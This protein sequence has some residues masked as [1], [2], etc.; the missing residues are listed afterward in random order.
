M[1]FR[2]NSSKWQYTLVN[3]V[4]LLMM[5]TALGQT[6]QAQTWGKES[7]TRGKVWM[8]VHNAFRLGEVDLPWPFYSMDYPGHSTGP[9][10]RKSV[11]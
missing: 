11:V 4:V 1:H 5:L 3:M 10:D 8:T 6:L 2:K 9:R 7:L